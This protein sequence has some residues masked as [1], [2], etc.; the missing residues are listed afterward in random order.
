MRSSWL[1]PTI[2]I[3]SAGAVSLVTF[4][5]P[6]SPMRPIVVMWFLFICPGIALVRLLRLNEPV[7]DWTLA[8]ALS[9]TIDAI[10]AGIQ[11]YAGRWSPTLTLEI[12]IALSLAGVIMQL[13]TMHS[14][15]PCSTTIP[16]TRCK[17]KRGTKP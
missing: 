17:P 6:A 16:A 7:V 14:E 11:L 13:A 15:T 9:F 5:I 8:I 2:I 1:W 3:L 10:V 12:L 4:V